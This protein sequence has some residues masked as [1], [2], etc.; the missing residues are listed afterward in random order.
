MFEDTKNIIGQKGNKEEMVA[1]NYDDRPDLTM[2]NFS[3]D[4]KNITGQGSQYTHKEYIFNYENGNPD[5]TQRSMSER[6]KNIT[7]QKGD[8]TQSRSR[9]DYSNALLN[10]VKENIAKG[11]APTIVKDNKGPTCTF[12]EYTFNDD[13]P[14]VD[15]PIYS[16][17]KTIGN[18]SNPLYNFA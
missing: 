16:S 11:R 14:I 13:R 18:I 4:T 5:P 17:T 3:E 2:R 15:R 1:F 7:G 6:T 9:L 10:T 8:G 12:T